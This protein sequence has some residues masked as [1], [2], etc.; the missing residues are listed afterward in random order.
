MRD[1]KLKILGPPGTGKTSH[2]LNILEKEI[3]SGTSPDRIAFLT[4]T[5][6][7]RE[8]ALSRTSK[9]ENEFPYL[10]TIHSIC[11]RQLELVKDQI[12]RP[13]TIRTFGRKIGVKLLGNA[14]DP[15]VEEFDHYFNTPTRDDILLQV[16]HYGR[17]RGILLKEALEETSLEVDYK[18][19]VWFTRAY[20][21]WKRCSGV[22]DYTD[23]LTKY[24]EQGKPLDVDVIFVDEAQD[25]SLLQW[26]V[27]SKLG[28]KADR[29]YIAGDDDQAIFHWAGA[30]S[31]VFQ[32][33]SV[34]KTEVLNQSYRVSRAVHAAASAI[35]NRIKR[36]LSK[37]YAP[38][39]SDGEARDIGYL[40]FAEFNE[41]TFV[42]FRNHFRGAELARQLNLES[43]PYIGHGSPLQ[44]P[45][46]RMA[47]VGW[48]KIIKKGEVP[49][50]YARKMLKY[51]NK[52]YTHFDV[53]K[54]VNG[55][56][57]LKMNEI[58]IRTPNWK[59]WRI[60]MRDMPGIDSITNCVNK[61]GFLATAKP[62]TELLSI[63]QSKGREA[64]NVIL[65]T[66]ISKAV[67]NGVIRDPDNEHRVWYVG[68]TRAKEKIMFLSPDGFYAYKV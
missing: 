27:V 41:K 59:D 5:R 54:K 11:Y 35:S 65:D 15:W 4:F 30:D 13:V 55:S 12:V 68:T 14:V 25:L 34:D 48:H 61:Y 6:A 21:E 19:A 52:E 32:E 3:R 42:L 47:L 7:A 67:Y 26:E 2:L 50:L 51:I 39:D 37:E 63:H 40:K 43:I 18:Y 8:E 22:M 46:I 17:H 20:R 56:K 45:D 23:L 49:S 44:N 58:F 16:N 9:T 36:R 64:T 62:N 57:L 10:R 29:W 28:A 60:L 38:R 66:E 33:L 1:M 24:I 31:S 53:N